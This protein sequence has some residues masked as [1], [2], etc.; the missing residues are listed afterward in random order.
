MKNIKPV[1]TLPTA[2]KVSC[3]FSCNTVDFPQSLR[4]K[5]AQPPRWMS[6]MSLH[7]CQRRRSNLKQLLKL[8]F[9]LEMEGKRSAT[10]FFF[11]YLDIY[12]GCTQHILSNTLLHVY[13][14]TVC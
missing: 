7:L 10:I 12:C 13:A 3:H 8:Q 14:V 2:D 6:W 1:L 4:L 5:Q 11:I 9:N